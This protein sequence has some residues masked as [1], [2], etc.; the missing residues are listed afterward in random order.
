MNKNEKLMILLGL[1]FSTLSIGILPIPFAI[2]GT[3][4]GIVLLSKNKPGFGVYILLVSICFGYIGFNL[5]YVSGQLRSVTT[6]YDVG[7]EVYNMAQT[8][9]LGINIVMYGL[10]AIAITINTFLYFKKV[11]NQ[12]ENQSDEPKK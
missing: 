1:I 10:L 3:I 11:K 4:L 12:K 7:T 5:G 6:P 8:Q 2:V 9:L